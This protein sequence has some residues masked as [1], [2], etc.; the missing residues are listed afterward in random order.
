[1]PSIPAAPAWQ[2]LAAHYEEM[3][4]VTL[5]DLFAA[6]RQRAS[7]FTL[8]FK[9]IFLDYSKN[10]VD[11]RTMRLL[12]A[13]AEASPLR[14]SVA[15]MFS[16]KRINVTE[17][18][19]VL[20]VALRNRSNR[21]IVAL[22]RDVMPG[23]NAVL[24]KMTGFCRQVR[25]GEWLGHS[26]RPI[27]NI[28]NLGIGGSDLGP[29]MACEALKPYA[30]P[31]LQVEFVSNVDGYH[32]ASVLSRLNPAETLFVV[33]SK[34][35]A[36]QETMTNALS[37]REWIL[38]AF[39]SR[40]AIARHFVAVSTHARAVSDFGIDPANMFEFWDWVGG[41][42]SLCSAIG[43]PL[44]LAIGPEHFAAMLQG[45]HEMD[46][47]FHTTP[48]GQNLPVVLALLGVWYNNF[49]EAQSQAILPYDQSMHRFAAHLQ[50]V[51]MES[52]G[53]NVDKEGNPVSWQTGPVIWGEPG[54]NSQHSFFQLLHQGTKLIPADFIGFCRSR[55]PLNSHHRKL[56][57][58][59][60]AQTEALAF[61]KSMAQVLAEEPHLSE[62]MARQ[63]SFPGNRPTTTIL[64]DELSPWTLGAL[65]A[66]YEHKIFVQGV[67]W[68]VYSFDQWGVQ[69]GKVLAD[70]ILE[71]FHSRQG[72]V[73]A[74]DASTEALIARLKHRGV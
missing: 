18:R 66:M 6:D 38:Q 2:A 27:R 40:E 15:G 54:T 43:L 13:L 70:R 36:T 12:L 74:H 57:A 64:A 25:R 58:S 21:P 9:D 19:P 33:A 31:E 67:L 48:Y 32:L 23:V 4:E 29:K 59:F 28:V 3:K 5:T 47:H 17:D 73:H 34:T 30:S 7:R 16:G 53:K 56:M 26:G 45:A 37:A 42:Y 46:E 63:K 71:D 11:A 61:G 1:M 72:L 60:V 39:A 10:R 62:A 20:H 65:L 22:G 35:F 50:Q 44:M 69:L 51:D 68:N 14:E 8:E 24:Q 55:T 52:N 49:F 41:R